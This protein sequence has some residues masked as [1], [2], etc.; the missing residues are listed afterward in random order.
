VHRAA[1]IEPDLV[2]ALE[3]R[4]ARPEGRRWAAG[5][6]LST[7]TRNEPS[8]RS[9]GRPRR[10]RSAALSWRSR[11][12]GRVLRRVAAPHQAPGQRL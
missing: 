6:E 5:H 11:P 9:A 2:V 7:P 4:P 10:S 12:A 3:Q 1:V 8:A